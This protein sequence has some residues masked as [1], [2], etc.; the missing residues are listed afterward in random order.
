[1][2]LGSRANRC[3][4]QAGASSFVCGASL[5]EQIFRPTTQQYKKAPSGNAGAFL[6]LA[7]GTAMKAGDE[8]GDFFGGGPRSLRKAANFVGN[9]SKTAARITARA[10][11]KQIGLLCHTLDHIP[12]PIGNHYISPAAYQA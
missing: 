12:M 4:S 2:A 1:M 11:S 5:R 7:V 3:R 9:G 10:A 8:R 6:C